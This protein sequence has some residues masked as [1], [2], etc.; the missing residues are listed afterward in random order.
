MDKV[1]R[2]RTTVDLI[3][4]GRPKVLDVEDFIKQALHAE[5][6]IDGDFLHPIHVGVRPVERVE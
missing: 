4:V 6:V 3:F 5:Q 2:Y 1:T